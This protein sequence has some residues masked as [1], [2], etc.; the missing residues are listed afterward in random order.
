MMRAIERDADSY[1]GMGKFE[2]RHKLQ[3]GAK[4]FVRITMPALP[5]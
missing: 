5:E 3:N 2:A 1:F 4:V